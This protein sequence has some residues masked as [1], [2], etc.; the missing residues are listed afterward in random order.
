M[1]FRKKPVV[2][3]AEQ[4]RKDKMPYPEGVYISGSYCATEEGG[5]WCELHKLYHLYP[6]YKIKTLEGDHTVSHLDWIITGVQGEKYPCKPDI[7]EQ[8][9]EYETDNTAMK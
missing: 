5:E 6:I 7:F 4:F 9:Y 3:D 1:K 2:V 8:T